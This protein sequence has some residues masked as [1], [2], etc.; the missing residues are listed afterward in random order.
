MYDRNKPTMPSGQATTTTES[1]SGVGKRTLVDT[2]FRHATA[3]EAKVDE[4]ALSA[5][6]S[7]SAQPLPGALKG[8]LEHALGSDLSGVRVHTGSESANAA[9]QLNANAYAVGQHIHFAAGAYDPGSKAGQRLIA[10]ETAHTV[11]QSGGAHTPQLDSPSVSSRGDAHEVEA[12]AFA[13]SFVAGGTAPVTHAATATISRD[14]PPG[15]TEARAI[16]TGGG[17]GVDPE[18]AS[19]D[20]A[21][22]RGRVREIW[23]G[24]AG[25]SHNGV[26]DHKIDAV[27]DMSTLMSQPDPPSLGQQLLITAISVGAGA[28]AGALGAG[29]PTILVNALVWGGAGLVTSLPQ[30][31]SSGGPAVNPVDYCARFRSSLRQGWPQSLSTLHGSMTTDEEARRVATG[32][33]QLH[34]DHDRIR[35]NQRGEVLDAW[36]VALNQSRS[37]PDRGG[38]LGGASL[39]DATEGRLH[40]GGARIFYMYQGTNEVPQWAHDPMDATMEGVPGPDARNQ[41][42]DR[43]VRDIHAPRTMNIGQMRPLAFAPPTYVEHFTL[44]LNPAGTTHTIEEGGMG[45]VDGKR[46]LSSFFLGVTLTDSDPRVEASWASGAS[47]VW[48]QINDKTLRQMGIASV[49]N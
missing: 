6:A 8:S 1:G 49:G 15:G 30:F 9:K 4:P 16:A 5:A 32:V 18:F 44:G 34:A 19:L 25:Y 46:V 29:F 7:S 45:L 31:F 35:I 13:Q 26:L 20:A 2:I 47:K 22:L 37:N 12:E 33:K 36:Q 41:N 48:D 10:H 42:L 40:L 23:I 21:A 17:A 11:Q 27:N 28:A 24:E 43:K 3:S 14:D 39:D 38:G